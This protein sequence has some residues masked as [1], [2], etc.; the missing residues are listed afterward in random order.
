M[1]SKERLID[2]NEL[3]KKAYFEDEELVVCIDDIIGAP[4]V[5]AVEVVR[6]KACKRWRP[7]TDGTQGMCPCSEHLTKAE[8]Y[9]AYGERK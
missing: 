2:A 8:H 7:W 3:V 9:C 6:C 1:K 5:D 4:T